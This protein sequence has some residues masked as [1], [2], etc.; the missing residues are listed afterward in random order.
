[1]SLTIHRQSFFRVAW[2]RVAAAAIIGLGAC[3]PSS[4]VGPLVEPPE[5]RLTAIEAASPAVD[6]SLSPAVP[7]ARFSPE[8]GYPSRGSLSGYSGCNTY[9]ARFTA[10]SGG[11][12]H[13]EALFT[14]YVGC[15]PVTGPIEAAYYQHVQRA[16]SYRVENKT[17]RIFT[18]EGVTLRFDRL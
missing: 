7:T 13:V 1:M 3:A 6:V 11:Q 14:T 18:N 5:W 17:L 8:P 12:L 2:S 10:R 4:A 16:V 15:T 9:G